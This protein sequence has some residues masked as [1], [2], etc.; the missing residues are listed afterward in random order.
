MMDLL[1]WKNRASQTEILSTHKKF[2]KAFLYKMTVFA[3]GCR[4]ILCPD[5][6]GSLKSRKEL[7]I[8]HYNY[9]GSWYSPKVQEWVSQADIT[10][11]K[12]L[13]EMRMR[14]HSHNIKVR[15]EEPYV[16]IYACTEEKLKELCEL[17]DNPS[18]VKSVSGPQSKQAET[19][20]VDNKILRKRKPKWRYKIAL[21][22]KKFSKDIKESI[23]NY[24]LG[25]GEEIHM[26][27]M[28]QHQLTKDH[29]W[30][31]GCYFYTNDSGVVNMLRLID[32]DMVREVS[33]M[34]QVGDK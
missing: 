20:L 10:Q 8:G 27:N 18:S 16:D 30:I 11:L 5:I 33:E 32:P 4:S 12:T 23:W 13:Q 28:A 22:D 6:A 24:L 21:K 15:V 31:W 2:Y 17:L 19:L 34:V 29:E 14:S 26:P 3:P 7:V 9:G 25:I 1:Y